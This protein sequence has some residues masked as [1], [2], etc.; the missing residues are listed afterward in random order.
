[1]S[2]AS[3]ARRSSSSC[4]VWIARAPC[5]K[6]PANNVGPARYREREGRVSYSRI[7]RWVGSAPPSGVTQEVL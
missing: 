6:G 7:S 5:R 3:L 2:R 4:K 1:V